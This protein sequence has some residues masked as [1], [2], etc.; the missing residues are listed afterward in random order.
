MPEL[1]FCP[2]CHLFFEQGKEKCPHCGHPA[3]KPD[4]PVTV[5]PGLEPPAALPPH[6]HDPA[7]RQL[8]SM[9]F[10]AKVTGLLFRPTE[11][12]RA[13]EDESPGAAYIHFLISLAVFSIT[14]T[15]L[16][17]VVLG[18]MMT[19]EGTSG[20]S[21]TSQILSVFAGRSSLP[22]LFSACLS[23]RFF[24]SSCTLQGAGRGSGK[25]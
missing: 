11:T 24:T 4:V 14:F 1:Q 17:F 13:L 19:A 25:P 6:R 12:F 10:V 16:F 23:G 20:F 9:S 7:P 2:E 21:G 5:R 3:G 15:A 8:R 18:S 22:G